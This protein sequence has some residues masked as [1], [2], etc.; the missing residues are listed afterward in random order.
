MGL[1]APKTGRKF[2]FAD[3]RS[4]TDEERS[5]VQEYLLVYPEDEMVERYRLVNG[6]YLSA[7][8]F[9]WDETLKLVALPDI[10]IN[11]WEIFARQRPQENG[12]I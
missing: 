4:W 6:Q 1:T 9:N 12:A 8:V 7:D 3:Y 2:T 10:T 11:L 5:G